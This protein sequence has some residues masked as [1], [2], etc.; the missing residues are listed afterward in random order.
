MA[1]KIILFENILNGNALLESKEIKALC[2][3]QFGECDLSLGETDKAEELKEWVD[4]ELHKSINGGYGQ[5]YIMKA[6]FENLQ[7]ENESGEYSAPVNVYLFEP[8]AAVDDGI[9]VLSCKWS[10]GMFSNNLYVAG[11]IADEDDLKRII[12][13]KICHGIAEGEEVKENMPSPELVEKVLGWGRY[14]INKDG[15]VDVD[16]IPNFRLRAED[17]PDGRLPFHFGK[18]MC[19]MDCSRCGLTT[20]E[21]A[22]KYVRGDFKCNNNKLTSLIGGPETVTGSFHCQNNQL[23]SLEGAPKEVGHMSKDTYTSFDTG[24]SW[25]TGYKSY[26]EFDCQNNKIT[27]L[28]G[29]DMHVVGTFRC[30]GNCISQKKKFNVVVEAGTVRWGK[31]NLE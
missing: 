5:V 27:S 9:L 8:D 7:G 14:T 25:V 11:V 21:G 18:V 30:A 12:I 17:C 24:E 2:N 29:V 4:R 15:S 20:L 23:T 28:E 6:P 10:N 3:H 16:Y 13:T 31:Q 1:Q 22:P 19:D 26:D